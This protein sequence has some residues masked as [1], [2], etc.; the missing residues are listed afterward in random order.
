MKAM[1]LLAGEDGESEEVAPVDWGYPA[2]DDERVVRY[3]SVLELIV[4]H[5]VEWHIAIL[6]AESHCAEGC[7]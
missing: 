1:S 5:C 7:R 3:T 2:D 4:I 6:L